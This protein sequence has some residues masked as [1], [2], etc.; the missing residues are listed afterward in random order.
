MFKKLVYLIISSCCLLLA[1]QVRAQDTA[2]TNCGTTPEYL[3]TLGV[4]AEILMP[5]PFPATAIEE[6][7]K[8]QIYYY[9]MAYHPGEGFDDPFVGATRRNTLCAVLTYIQ[10]VYDFSAIPPGKFIRLRVDTSYTHTYH[11]PPIFTV[12]HQ[13]GAGGPFY[14]ASVPAGS[15][16]NGY[17]NDYLTSTTGTDPAP[18]N[19]HCDLRMNFDSIQAYHR[20][21]LGAMG[22]KIIEVDFQNGLGNPA[23]CQYDLFGTMLHFMTHSLGQF[24][25]PLKTSG[26]YSRLDTSLMKSPFPFN[27]STAFS[28]PL[29]P[30]YP[31]VPSAPVMMWFGRANIPYRIA[32]AGSHMLNSYMGERFGSGNIQPHVTGEWIGEGLMYRRYTKEELIV[33]N[34]ILGLNFNASTFASTSASAFYYNNKRPYCSKNFD[35][36][37]NKGFIKEIYYF[38]TVAADFTLTNDISSSLVIN[39]S[40]DTSLHD[41]D[42]DVLS[43]VPESI[44]NYRGCGVGGNNHNSIT[45]SNS[46]RTITYTPRHNFYGR[47]QFGMTISDGKEEGTFIIYTV[48]V[49]KG[50]NISLPVDG[51]YVLNGDF[52]EGTEVRIKGSAEEV[53]ILRN[54]QDFTSSSGF[55]GIKGHVNFADCQPYSNGTAVRNSYAACSE[56]STAKSTFGYPLTTFPWYWGPWAGTSG[57]PYYHDAYLGKGDRY[58][59]IH[60]PSMYNLADSIRKCRSYVLEFDVIKP[61]GPAYKDYFPNDTFYIGF[62]DGSHLIKTFPANAYHITKLPPYVVPAFGY[63]AWTHYR[64]PFTYCSD[65]PATVLSLKLSNLFDYTP[66]ITDVHNY[67]WWFPEYLMDNVSIKEDSFKISIEDTLISPCIVRLK[68]KGGTINSCGGSKYLWKTLAGKILDSIPEIDVSPG[69]PTKYILTSSNGCRIASDTIEVGGMN[70]P[71]GPGTV[72][73]DTVS[74]YTL[75]GGS[76][77]S[78]PATANYYVTNDITLDAD[79]TFKNANVLMKEWVKVTVS[80]DYKLTLDSVHMFTCP[81]SAWM[82][83]GITLKS[84]ASSSARIEVKNNCLIEDAMVAIDAQDL[85]TPA[86]GDV[87]NVTYS[88]FNRNQVDISMNNYKV[89]SPARL[90]ITIKGNLFTARKFYRTSIPGYPRTWMSTNT[91]KAATAITDSKPPYYISKTPALTKAKCKDTTIFSHVGVRT[92]DIGLTSGAGVYQ[93]EVWIGEGAAND[94]Y[95]LFDNH[96]YGVISFNSNITLYHNH[97]INISRRMLPFTSATAPYANGM[98]VILKAD[99]TSNN[100]AQVLPSLVSGNLTNKFHDC[101]TGIYTENIATLNI[102]TTNMT[103]SNKAGAVVAGAKDAT[104]TYTG[105]GIM[106]HCEGIQK[107]NNITGNIISNINVGIQIAMVNPKAGAVTTVNSNFLYS[108]NL[109]PS[110]APFRGKQCMSQ[111]INVYASGGVKG[112]ANTALIKDN[113]LTKVLNGILIQGLTNVKCSTTNNT[114]SLWDTATPMSNVVQYGIQANTNNELTISG[115]AVSNITSAL[116]AD[117]V[118]GVMGGSNTVMRICGNTTNNIGRGFEFSKGAAQTGTR[119]I[120]NTMNNGYKGMVLASDIGDQGLTYDYVKMFPPSFWGATGNKWTG[121]TWSLGSSKFQT[122]GV[123]YISTMNSKLW[124]KDIP[125]GTTERPTVNSNTAL[126]PFPNRYDYLSATR[127]IRTTQ[128]ESNCLGAIYFSSYNPLPKG[129]VSGG[130]TLGLLIMADSLGYDSTY[131]VRQWMSQLSLYELGTI[132]PD[133][134]DSSAALD[135]FM[136]EAAASRFAWLTDIEKAINTDDLSTAQTLLNN[137]VSAMGRVVVN[138]DLI[139]TDYAEAD[140]VVTN[141]TDYY[142]AYLRYLQGTMTGNDSAAIQAITGKCPVKDG[143]VVYKARSLRQVLGFES[144]VYDDDSCEYNNGGLYR[145]APNDIIDGENNQYSLYPNPNNGSFVLKQA[146]AENKVVNLKVYN[147]I[148]AVVYQTVAT[149]VNGQFSIDLKQKAHGVYL[150]C[151]GDNK[152]KYTCLRFIIN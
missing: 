27:Y 96:E 130:K 38:D 4:T 99:K 9:D 70:C 40:A 26:N 152:E 115:N 126:L 141:Y 118:R 46:N 103:T 108:E 82:W 93:S 77:T 43:V 31:V 122:V 22:T 121:G 18:L 10:S 61:H 20:Y 107:S 97:F 17:V 25:S 76:L 72:F 15:V 2:H 98:G 69:A 58:Q 88:T 136:N 140:A 105:Y 7:G 74:F 68:A 1:G 145:I 8:F 137:P 37:Y 54:S 65:T 110:Y 6:C 30:V 106:S 125:G 133:L 90:P 41:D 92:T 75:S 111:G 144:Y 89:S 123:D 28:T 55:I 86:S 23:N 119:W 50:T 149:F 73:G 146:V 3:A 101:F 124:V 13:L 114:I 94:D 11:V 45:L 132:S 95:N 139:I 49:E 85:R 51:N 47:A 112:T 56:T 100:K 52:E 91:L 16:V 138:G 143:A 21:D 134:R 39:L 79:L 33:G 84:G 81:D 67:L 151:I 24:S 64:I 48:D 32:S 71:C 147:A 59:T 127:S 60:L 135:S 53:K 78:I 142:A 109:D 35:F 87:I 62:T 14:P 66:Y 34:T 80:P 120:G 19:F 131:R 36:R 44:I 150:V 63:T 12:F 57:A 129:M 128:K 5:S 104:E 42:G 116:T 29:V 113:R 117:R 83:K 102:S 148:G